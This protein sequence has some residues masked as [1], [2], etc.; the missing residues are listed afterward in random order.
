MLVLTR[1]QGESIRM[2]AV[3]TIPAGTELNIK[4]TSTSDVRCK[5]G[6][7]APRALRITRPEAHPDGIG[8]TSS[9]PAAA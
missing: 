7:E 2:V 8:K 3:E 9:S 1:K 4:V 5:L 6:I